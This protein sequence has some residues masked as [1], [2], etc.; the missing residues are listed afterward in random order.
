MSNQAQTPTMSERGLSPK[1]WET[2][3]EGLRDDLTRHLDERLAETIDFLPDI[4]AKRNIK[5]VPDVSWKTRLVQVGVVLGAAA[6]GGAVGAYVGRRFSIKTR[7]VES[8]P[9]KETSAIRPRSVSGL[10]AA[11]LN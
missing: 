2:I 1:E 5:F 7:V 10:R 3:R 9:D 4:M 11:Q 6:I 8:E